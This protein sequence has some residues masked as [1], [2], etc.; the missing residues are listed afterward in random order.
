MNMLGAEIE[1]AGFKDIVVFIF[2]A[3]W[4]NVGAYMHG[5]AKVCVCV[6]VCV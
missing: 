3:V 4:S 6:C 2:D 5:Q 1:T